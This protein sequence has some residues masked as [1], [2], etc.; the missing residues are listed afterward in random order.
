MARFLSL[1]T[2]LI[3]LAVSAQKE[4]TEVIDAESLRAISINSEEIYKVSVTTAPVKYITITTR[5]NGEYYNDIRLESQIQENVL[6][7]RSRYRE[8]LQSGFDKLSAHKVFSM[9]IQLEIP[10]GMSVEIISN[11]SSV[12]ME[13]KY[14]GVLIQVKTGSVFLKD[15]NGDAI[16]NTFEGNINVQAKNAQYE[17]ETRHGGL[18]IPKEANGTNFL[19]LTSI[20]G[21]IKVQDTK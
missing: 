13:G 4:T 14:H 11:L 3:S 18:E 17:V 19:K 16:V 9:E 6:L 15:F 12:F 5:S 10:E 20:N 1:F 7:L 21:N 8:V 2:F